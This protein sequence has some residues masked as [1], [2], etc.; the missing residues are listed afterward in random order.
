MLGIVN[1]I[2]LAIVVSAILNALDVSLAGLNV[3]IILVIVI[4]SL[5]FFYGWTAIRRIAQ[6]SNHGGRGLALAGMWLGGLELCSV[7][8]GYIFAIIMA[9]L[10]FH[11]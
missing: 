11:D 10:T 7:V 3:C 4:G 5:S 2:I 1:I 6:N 9:L 8:I